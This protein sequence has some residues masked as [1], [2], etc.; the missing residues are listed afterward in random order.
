MMHSR[1][2]YN[3]WRSADDAGLMMQLDMT[4]Q[5]VQLVVKAGDPTLA[6]TLYR[7]LQA[8]AAEEGPAEG[9]SSSRR[10]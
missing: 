4:G 6:P 3:C 7:L 5:A 9:S 10:R 8:A 2:C 1:V